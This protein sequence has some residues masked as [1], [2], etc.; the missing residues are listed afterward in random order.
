MFRVVDKVVGQG[1]V[2]RW[3]WPVVAR[4]VSEGVRAS[5]AWDEHVAPTTAQH[6]T[7]N[8]TVV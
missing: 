8:T 3:W 2:E 7:S 1:A 5:V 6:I 4:A